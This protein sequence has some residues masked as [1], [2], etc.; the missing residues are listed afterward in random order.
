[1]LEQ[2]EGAGAPA[3]TP[4]AST[5]LCRYLDPICIPIEQCTWKYSCSKNVSDDCM[6]MDLRTRTLAF[7]ALFAICELLDALYDATSSTADSQPMLLWICDGAWLLF[8][9]LGIY[10]AWNHESGWARPVVRFGRVIY[11]ITFAVYIEQWIDAPR[12]CAEQLACNTMDEATCVDPKSFF[13]NGALDACVTPCDDG[14]CTVPPYGRVPCVDGHRN[15]WNSTASSC[16]DVVSGLSV[17]DCAF[18]SRLSNYLKVI[19]PKITI[20]MCVLDWLLQ[21][22]CM[23]HVAS[24]P[25]PDSWNRTDRQLAFAALLIGTTTPARSLAT[26]TA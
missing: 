26:E 18:G 19:L 23:P 4:G 7:G 8:V 17:D 1:M 16:S 5:G 20:G 12:W 13:C 15:G 11:L 21:S 6:G 25:N 14:S 22:P 9:F 24:R 2:H 10:S 3:A